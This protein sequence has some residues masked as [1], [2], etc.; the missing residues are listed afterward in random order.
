MPLAAFGVDPDHAL[1]HLGKHYLFLSV[2]QS[3]IP[4]SFADNRR[5]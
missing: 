3:R 1:I 4:R 5:P 2:L